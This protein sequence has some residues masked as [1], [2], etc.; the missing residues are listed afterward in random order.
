MFRFIHW[1]GNLK[2]VGPMGDGDYDLFWKKITFYSISGAIGTQHIVK[3]YLGLITLF[4]SIHGVCI[5]EE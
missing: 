3:F 5:Y 4:L 2:V 1:L